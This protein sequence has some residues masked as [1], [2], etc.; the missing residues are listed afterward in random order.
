MIERMLWNL[1]GLWVPFPLSKSFSSSAHHVDD[2][3]EDTV[4]DAE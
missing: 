4:D 1:S 3:D 2:D